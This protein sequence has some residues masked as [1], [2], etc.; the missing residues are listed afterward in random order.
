[1]FG[2]KTRIG[3]ALAAGLCIAT[4]AQAAMSCWN[5]TQV[6]AAQIRDLQSRLMVAS[7]RCVAMGQD[8][9][10]AYNRF[11]RASRETLQGANGVILAQFR[12]GHGGEAQLHYDRFA[13]AL[14]NAYGAGATTAEI[15]AET[16]QLAEEAAAAAGDVRRLV[17]IAER[18]GVAPS[19]PGGH[20]VI[21]FASMAA[22][23]N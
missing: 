18:L 14:A 17:Q 19:L 5:Q 20:C 1:M 22:S 23:P 3:L 10:P 2:R 13:T 9:T 16:A 6:A 11:V 12:A 4:P 21:S 8:V 15:C 7:L